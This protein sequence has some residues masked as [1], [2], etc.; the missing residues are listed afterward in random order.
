[1]RD[2]VNGPFEIRTGLVSMWLDTNQNDVDHPE[3]GIEISIWA[4]ENFEVKAEKRHTHH[5]PQGRHMLRSIRNGHWY[6]VGS[7]KEHKAPFEI[8]YRHV[9]VLVKD[10]QG[11][12]P[13]EIQVMSDYKVLI[14]GFIG[15]TVI[16]APGK[17][18]IG[19]NSVG[20]NDWFVSLDEPAKLSSCEI[21]EGSQVALLPHI[22]AIRGMSPLV[23]GI[24][25]KVGQESAMV[26]WNTGV[27]IRHVELVPF[28]EIE[29]VHSARN[30]FVLGAHVR[31]RKQ[32]LSACSIP[33]DVVGQIYQVF[34]DGSVAVRWHLG[35]NATHDTIIALPGESLEL[36]GYPSRPLKPARQSPEKTPEACMNFLDPKPGTRV[37]QR[38]N[39]RKGPPHQVPEGTIRSVNPDGTVLVEWDEWVYRPIAYYLPAYSPL[40]ELE[41]IKTNTTYKTD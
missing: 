16:G 31:Q 14:G 26:E 19:R 17:Y 25:R 39:N 41:F 10:V 28:G 29:V 35:Q 40:S 27:G 6:F 22:A 3:K 32:K 11:R 37:V 23:T 36:T 4:R 8:Q 21:Q 12:S 34:D 2:M 18:T 7:T 9:T 15:D 30:Q 20:G 1:M 5:F 33:F 38:E 13:E 24:V